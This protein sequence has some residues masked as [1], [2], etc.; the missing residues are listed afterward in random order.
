[1][2][3]S[4]RVISIDVFRGLTILIMV[5]V[6]DVASVKGLPW[7][8]YHIP[9]GEQ[10][11]T[12]VDVVYPAFLF[13]VGMSIPIAIEKRLA[14]G[15]SKLRLISHIL[16]R[17]ISLAIIGLLIMNGRAMSPELTGISY[18]LWNVLM[19]VGVILFWNLYPKKVDDKYWFIPYLKWLG[20]ALLLYLLIV[21]KREV[22]GEPQWIHPR[23][24]SILGGIAFAYFS[25]CLIY[26]VNKNFYYLLVIYI[27][28]ILLDA[29]STSGVIEFQ[30]GIH[31]LI[32]PF[33]SGTT[34]AITLAGLMTSL[35]F[36]KNYFGSLVKNKLLAGSVF[37]MSLA[38]AG[39]LLLPYGLSKIMGTPSWGI[40]SSMYSLIVFVILYVLIDVYGKVRW[41]NFIRP[42]GTNPL[43]TYLLPDV[44]YAIFTV[45]WLQESTGIGMAGVV[46]ALMFTL[47]ILAWS[48][49]MTKYKIR[50][51]M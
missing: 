46:R 45:Q 34:A 44:F 49:F 25:V 37:T 39:Y 40:L 26:L 38:L 28:L 51:Q 17:T 27:A 7:W 23:N 4:S 13:I 19:F 24:W 10:G 22:D 11:L 14:K 41:A 1:M 9:G 8:T 47:F 12:Y 31:P 5:F 20:M 2:K 16:I 3:D 43:L 30:R 48:A 42:A 33:G 36:V 32:W 15:F 50:L 21:Y 35:I 6:N 29:G 18:P